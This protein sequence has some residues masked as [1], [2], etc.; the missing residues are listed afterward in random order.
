MAWLRLRNLDQSL[1]NLFYSL[2]LL[3][4]NLRRSVIHK[5]D[6][7]R[8]RMILSIKDWHNVEE[9]WEK[10]LGYFGLSLSRIKSTR[11]I[12]NPHMIEL[13]LYLLKLLI[14]LILGCITL[15]VNFLNRVIGSLK[16]FIKSS[17]LRYY[18]IM[19]DIFALKRALVS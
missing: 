6:R 10:L 16:V 1:R 17:I 7:L 18:A 5:I 9:I 3:N 11:L 19:N 13:V 2:Y 4:V 15:L 12:L 14:S 8:L